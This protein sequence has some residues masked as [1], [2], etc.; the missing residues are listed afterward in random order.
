MACVWAC[1][2]SVIR[3]LPPV[4]LVVV[5]AV[6][7]AAQQQVKAVRPAPAPWLIILPPKLVSGANATLAVLDHQGRLMPKVEVILSS[8]EKLT[9]DATGR[10][11]FKVNEA[12]GKLRAAI[13]GGAVA[14]TA[15][16]VSAVNLAAHVERVRSGANVN[17]YPRIL[18]THDRFTLEGADF[19]GDADGNRVSLNGDPCFVLASSPESLVALPGKNVPVGDATLRVEVGGGAAEFPV[20]VVL[21]EFSGPA[22]S[23]NA[24]ASGQLILHA[25]G[26]TQPL[27]VE[28]R[29][30]SPDVIQLTKGNAQRLKTSG[31]E[32]NS[33]P[34]DVKF[35]TAGNYVVSAR[36]VSSGSKPPDSD[37]AKK[38][39]AELKER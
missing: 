16:V 39:L 18:A 14:A 15:D 19:R 21:L 37:P 26:S 17:T 10:S 31:G 1:R 2:K 36:L 5:S 28:V 6:T 13:S 27:A 38:R 22:E 24:G 8:G 34:V 35:V 11:T 25:R 9:T 32:D 4:L 30:A 12:G 7:V 33:V 29:N 3:W 20:S 23:V